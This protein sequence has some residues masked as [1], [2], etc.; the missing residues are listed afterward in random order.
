MYH[1]PARPCCT[2]CG[3]DNQ[4]Y[5][6][7]G[8]AILTL[9]VGGRKRSVVTYQHTIHCPEQDCARPSISLDYA[10]ACANLNHPARQKKVNPAYGVRFL[11]T[12]DDPLR[13]KQRAPTSHSSAKA[14]SLSTRKETVTSLVLPRPAAASTAAPGICCSDAGDDGDDGSSVVVAPLVLGPCRD[15]L[16]VAVVNVGRDVVRAPWRQYGTRQW[17]QNPW[18]AAAT[19]NAEKKCAWIVRLSRSPLS[20]MSS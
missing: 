20:S 10:R 19:L 12:Q 5:P 15:A 16:A 3:T 8:T 13:S 11:S 18:N 9:P 1:K 14:L 2:S 7:P 17:F 4:R 6:P